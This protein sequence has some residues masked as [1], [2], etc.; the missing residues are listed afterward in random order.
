VGVLGSSVGAWIAQRHQNRRDILS[1]KISHREQ[2]YSDFISENARAMAD[3]LQHEFQDP[4]SLTP[5]YA[6][7]SRIRLSSSGTCEIIC[8]AAWHSAR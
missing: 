2:L 7:L 5:S 1:K 3:A 6:L 4:S 8:A